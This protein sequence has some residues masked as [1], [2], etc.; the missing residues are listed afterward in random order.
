MIKLTL[1]ST[2]LAIFLLLLGAIPLYAQKATASNITS[3]SQQR[4]SVIESYRRQDW[5]GRGSFHRIGMLDSQE[6]SIGLALDGCSASTRIAASAP[7]TSLLPVSKTARPGPL[8]RYPRNN[9]SGFRGSRTIFI[10]RREK[11]AVR[12]LPPFPAEI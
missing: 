7:R 12:G 6:Q 3:A 9:V 5:T 2:V 11:G 4:K 10:D 8:R 1:P